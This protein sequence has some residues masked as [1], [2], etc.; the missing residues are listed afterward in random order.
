MDAVRRDEQGG[1]RLQIAD[2]FLTLGKPLVYQETADGKKFVEGEYVLS[3]D[4]Q[5][6]LKL[7]AY[8]ASKPLIIDPVLSYSSYL[9]GSGAEQGMGV[10]VDNSGNIYLVGQTA[11]VDFPLIT[12]KTATDTD[13][14]VAKFD[15]T[16]VLQ[17]A[18]ILGGS[19]KDRG[20]AIAADSGAVYIAGDTDSSDFPTKNAAQTV[21]G[22]GTTDIDA[23]VA[24][25]NSTDLTLVYSTY[26]GGSSAEEGLG[27]AVDGAGN[28][29]VA[30]ATMSNNFPFTVGAYQTTRNAAGVCNDPTNNANIIPCSDAFVAKYDP[31]GGKQYATFLGGSYEEAANAIAVSSAGVAYVTGVTYSGDFPG[32][33]PGT[34]LQSVNNGGAGDVF[35]ATLNADGSQVNYATYLGG[36]GWDQGQAIAV[37]SNG[38]IY[39]AGATNSVKTT[40]T[41]ISFPLISSL[42]QIYGGGSYDAFAVKLIPDTSVPTAYSFQYSTYLGG[43]DKDIAFG[44]AADSGGNAYVVGE[45][46]STDFPLDTSLQSSWFGGGSDQWGD[47][48]ITKISD[49]GQKTWST[50]LGG[51]DDDWANSVAVDGSGGVY[52]AG[53]SFSPDFPT[54]NPYQASAAGDSDALLFKLNDS[55]VTADL[56]VSVSGAPDPVGSGETLTY[57][58]TVN[59]LSTTSSAGGVVVTATLPGGVNFKSAIPS[60]SCSAAG[61]QVTCNMGTIAANGSA[62]TSLTTTA[63][64]AGSIT[65]TAKLARANQPDPNPANDSA[66]VTTTAAVGSSGGGAWSLLELLI[67]MIFYLSR[68]KGGAALR[69]V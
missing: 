4:K 39:V 7:A 50:Y 21:K 20:F 68:S 57:Q 29:Y 12:T 55:A 47:A 34:S 28:A 6:G 3:A 49:S 1:L 23:L 40:T 60:G 59:N 14:F 44:I 27:V 48:F 58:I 10:A 41:T 65:F 25:F 46:M 43:S 16:G 17:R 11:S 62:T 66:S 5:V 52:V 51:S 9:G 30:G 24:K 36:S 37:D 26:L 22:G 45:T 31:G 38:N 67:V 8:D 69:L 15:S 42:Q 64:A 56:K 53:S 54:V 35:I 61:A 63:D 18:A 32:I 2:R 13:V 19:G 33:A